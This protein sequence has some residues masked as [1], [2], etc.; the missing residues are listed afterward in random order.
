MNEC[1]FTNVTCD[2]K[3]ICKNTDG[4]YRC[5]CSLGYRGDGESCEDINECAMQ[6]HE[7]HQNATCIDTKG[8]YQCTCNPGYEGNGRECVDINECTTNRHDCHRN[9]ECRNKPGTFE[10]VCKLNFAGDGVYTCSDIDECEDGTHDCPVNSK[11][12]NTHG[13]H[14]CVCVEPFT[15]GSDGLCHQC[16]TTDLK[17]CHEDGMCDRY[18][19]R[20]I[21]KSGYEGDGKNCQDINECKRQRDVC[22]KG[23]CI[24]LKGDFRCACANG[25]RSDKIT[26]KCLDIDECSSSRG[27]LLCNG[28]GESCTNTNGGYACVSK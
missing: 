19:H 20:C 22:G 3:A 25:Y 27:H 1:L 7:C 14:K 16:T 5:E 11:C 24:N 2:P 15:L 13:S 26:K 23:R 6:V 17:N 18:S 28:T 21:C 12:H 4:S 8:S 9:A 10:C